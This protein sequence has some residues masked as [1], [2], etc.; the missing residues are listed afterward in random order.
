MAD[1]ANGR[2]SAAP[3]PAE[4][5]MRADVAGN[6]ELLWPYD[7]ALDAVAWMAGR[8]LG[9]VCVEAYDRVA[10]ARGSFEG[11]WP[12]APGWRAGERWEAYVARAAL[13]AAAT[14]EQDGRAHADADATAGDRD[15]RR[16]FLAATR[17]DAYPPTLRQP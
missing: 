10:Q 6:G 7:A 3:L 15:N 8:G 2:A 11:D 12:V 17:E 1:R 9:I 13:H 5:R 4:L 16:Y 14:I